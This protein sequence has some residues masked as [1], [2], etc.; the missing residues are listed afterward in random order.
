MYLEKIA[1][2]TDDREYGGG[3]ERGGDVGG[4]NLY[5]VQVHYLKGWLMFSKLLA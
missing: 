3:E 2:K 4:G 1:P 5:T